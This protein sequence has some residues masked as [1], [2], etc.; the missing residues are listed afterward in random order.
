MN[1]Q[2]VTNRASEWANPTH[3]SRADNNSSSFQSIPF[4]SGSGTKWKQH[5]ET[6]KFNKK[7]SAISQSPLSVPPSSHHSSVHPPTRSWCVFASKINTCRPSSSTSS[8]CCRTSQA[9]SS[10]SCSTAAN[11]ILMTN[12]TEKRLKRWRRPARPSPQ[13]FPLF[14]M[15]N[16]WNESY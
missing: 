8:C 10:S 5:R 16:S 12:Y 2:D 13:V 9:T 7:E 14:L 11:M 3:R 6:C 1:K 4:Q 15:N